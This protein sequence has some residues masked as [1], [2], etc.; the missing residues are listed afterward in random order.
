MRA[1]DEGLGPLISVIICLSGFKNGASRWGHPMWRA[2]TMPLKHAL[3]TVIA[4]LPAIPRGQEARGSGCFV[5]LA[6]RRAH[7]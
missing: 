2:F 3:Q 7:L 6:L 1:E 4:P 5:S